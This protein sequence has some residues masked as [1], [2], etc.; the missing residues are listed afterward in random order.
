MRARQVGP[1]AILVAL[2]WAVL[3]VPVLAV[4]PAQEGR[5]HI[6]QAGESLSEIAERY[7]VSVEAIA[8]A[9]DIPDA[10]WIAAGQQLVIPSI[11]ADPSNAPFLVP[12]AV[13][14]GDTLTLIARRY[15]ISPQAL[16]QAN[17]VVNPHLIHLGQTLFVPVVGSSASPGGRVYVV[18]P[19]DTLAS[20]ALRFDLS[21]WTVAAANG[22]PG[23]GVVYAGQ[24]LL[25]PTGEGA[26]SLPF[27]LVDVSLEPV[28]AVQ[29][30]TIQI[31]VRTDREAQLSGTF[32]GRPL[33]LVGS[34]GHYRALAGVP[35]MAPPGAYRLD[36]KA[37]QGEREVSIGSM[38]RIVAG[39]FGTSYLTFPSDKASLLAPDLLAAEAERVWQVTTRVTL[40]GTWQQPLALP[41]A[42]AH[43]VSARFGTR[44]SYG[45]GPA[46]SYH[47]GVDYVAATGT[48]VLAPAAGRV[49]LAEPLQ[50]R[51]N[52]VIVDHG[53][54]VM[55][56]YWHLSQIEVVPGQV[57]QR[58]ATLGRVGNTGLST[59]EHL[60]WELRVMG[61]PV[62]PLQWVS[63]HM[64]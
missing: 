31:A 15:R 21:T 62:D 26:A 43:N 42:G 9:N 10:H 49:V 48:P 63:Q 27:P 44:R 11:H 7:G 45:G 6:V 37:I 8:A 5:I 58:G 23:P 28:V 13:Q 30:Q 50:V 54:G 33:I 22:M 35:A 59:G 40:P 61:I 64:R 2:L 39:T 18:Q 29:G 51:G 36:L 1:R 46:N 16:A 17:H 47:A 56:G 25:I 20:I 4:P 34:D 53:R 3:C 60:H 38:V 57:V 14:P 32:D 41:L 52:A 19:G 55:T 24:R 12:R